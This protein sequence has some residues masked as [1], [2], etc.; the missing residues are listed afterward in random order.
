MAIDVWRDPE[1]VRLALEEI[2]ESDFV[3]AR[4]RREAAGATPETMERME[5]KIP[6]RT[7]AWGYYRFAEHLLHLDALRRAGVR[8]AERDLLGCE[9]EGML[10]LDRARTAFE[11][12]HPACSAC[13]H[14]Q[15]NRFGA[16]CSGCGA[17]FQRKKS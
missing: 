2:F 11:G 5:Q 9:A 3:R 1:G 7:L 4:I 16:E 6:P 13:G 8:F 15:Q 17:K 14:R 10:A 12:H